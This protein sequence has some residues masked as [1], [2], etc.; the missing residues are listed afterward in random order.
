M[1]LKVLVNVATCSAI[2]SRN[3]SRVI[4]IK[5]TLVFPTADESSID[6]WYQVLIQGT[7]F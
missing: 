7:L 1:L 3:S 5:D 6:V 2:T 4:D